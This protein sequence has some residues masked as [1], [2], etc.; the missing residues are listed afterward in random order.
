M[1][2][3]AR[4]AQGSG[5]SRGACPAVGELPPASRPTSRA[6]FSSPKTPRSGSTKASISSSCRN[7]SELDWARGQLLRGGEHHHAAA[8]E[9]PVSVAVE[10]SVAQASR[11]DH[12][13]AA[14]SR[15]AESADSRAVLNVI[16]WGDGIYGVE[17]AA[18]TYFRTSRGALGPRESA[19]L[20][21][22]IINPRLLNP[23]KPTARRPRGNN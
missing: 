4:E 12:R 1:E 17:A 13:A 9:E 6:R 14:R 20:A 18:R 19:L 2:L 21:G 22:A 16:E 11:A 5:R 23:A 8:R 3:R 7:R 10:E 15:A